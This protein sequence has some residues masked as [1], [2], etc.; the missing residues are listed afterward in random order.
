[1]YE[2]Q[3]K[4]RFTLTA[5]S[6]GLAMT[7]GAVMAQA[8]EASAAAAPISAELAPLAHTQLLTGV[9][10]AGEQLVAVG[11]RGHILRS[12]DGERWEQVVAPV[13]SLLTAVTFIDAQQG[14]A[15]GHDAVVLHTADGGRTWTLQH[16]QPDLNKALLDVLFLDA[17]HGF[18]VGA[19]GLLLETRDGGK[20]WTQVE[21][22]IVEEQLHFNALTRLGDGSLLLIG[23]E[24]MMARSEDQGQHWQRLQSPIGSS[25]FAVLAE[26]ERGALIAGLRGNVYRT[27]D[28]QSGNWTKVDTGDVQSVFGLTALPG[29]DVAM[30]GLNASLLRLDRD[31]K[32]QRLSLDAP[33]AGTADSVKS[34]DSGQELGAFSDAIAWKNALVVVGESGVRTVSI[35]R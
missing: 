12:A 8:D 32:V 10:R 27:A 15:V 18:A 11:I 25:Q 29:G 23:E 22:E 30:A 26:G 4:L 13:N 14:W 20:Q 28:V 9:A 21:G 24:G 1:M 35:K 7:A 17:Q 31:S 5:L 19:Y 6:L 33:A 3:R 34:S 2:T 16:F